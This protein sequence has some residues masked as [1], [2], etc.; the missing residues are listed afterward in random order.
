MRLN[1]C[2]NCAGRLVAFVKKYE[3]EIK[4]NACGQVLGSFTRAE[5]CGHHK[6]LDTIDGSEGG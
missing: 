4:C 1:V 3:V 6:P 2:P 5:F